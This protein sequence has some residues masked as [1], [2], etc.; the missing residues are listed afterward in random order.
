MEKE[1]LYLIGGSGFIGKNLVRCL[2]PYYQI[3]VFDKYIDYDFFCC[4]PEVATVVMNL[5]TEKIAAEY[6]TPS[7]I[8]NLASIVTAE[9]DLSLFDGLISSNL[10]ILLN[11]YDR[12]KGDD[13]LRLFIQFG[14][15]EEY[16]SEGSPFVETQRERPNSPYA[17]VKQLTTNTAIMLYDNYGFPTMVVRPGNLFGPGQNKS[18]FI[19]YVIEQLRKGE[20][21]NVSPCEQ[22]RDFIHV[23][24]FS[25]DIH[26]L[27]KHADRV[28]GQIVNVSSGQSISLRQIIDFYKEAL[29][30]TSEINYGALSY[31]ENEAMDLRCNIGKLLMIVNT[32]HDEMNAFKSLI[33]E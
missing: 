18:K 19:P 15:S 13:S 22:R 12:F 25:L 27:L 1:I 6:P 33:K 4:Y 14:S 3:T 11:L 21:L 8:I 26:G 29:H 7:F 24:V 28:V 5:A 9:R 23:D 17:L 32:E 16:G 31:R 2:S 20:P 10:K 30:S